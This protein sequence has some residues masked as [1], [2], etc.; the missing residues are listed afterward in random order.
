[1]Q[2]HFE[3]FSIYF[4]IDLDQL[5]Y[6]PSIYRISGLIQITN[7]HQEIAIINLLTL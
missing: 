3:L 1:M 6:K 7:H 5:L 2:W 4:Y